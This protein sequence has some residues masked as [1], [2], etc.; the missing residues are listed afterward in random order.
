MLPAPA[1]FAQW[2]TSAPSAVTDFSDDFLKARGLKRLEDIPSDD[3][4]AYAAGVKA[5]AKAPRVFA[6]P[7]RSAPKLSLL[8][9]PLNLVTGERL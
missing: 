1:V 5:A 6:P 8:G 4:P 7:V 9:N 3:L 2:W